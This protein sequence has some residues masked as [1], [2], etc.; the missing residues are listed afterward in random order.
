VHDPQ[1]AGLRRALEFVAPRGRE[2]DLFARL[3]LAKS[4]SPEEVKAAYHQI[5]RQFHPDKYAAP[6]LKDLQPTLQE[7][8]AAVNEAYT[9]LSDRARRQEYVARA[10]TGAAASSKEAADAARVDA[11]KAEAC[12]RT[13]D[14]G[15]ARLFLEAAIRADPRAEYHAAL[16]AVILADP[17]AADRARMKE[18]LAEATKDP[19][20]DRG[21][22]LA[23]VVARQDGEEARAEKMFRAAIAANPRNGDAA[24]ELKL[25]EGRRREAADA[26]SASKK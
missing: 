5:V 2:K 4:A 11:Q 21:F 12:Y 24:R 18:L 9:T 19:S 1:E 8:L 25:L 6:G 26:R 3:G 15:K 7:L 23:G 17:R 16:A 14:Y 20:C 10:G 13:R 22:F